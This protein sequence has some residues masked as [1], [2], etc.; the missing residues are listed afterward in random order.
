MKLSNELV[1]IFILVVIL[2]GLSILFD[3]FYFHRKRGLPLWERIGHPL[4][5]LSVIIC[6]SIIFILIPNQVNQYLYAAACLISCV[7]ITKDEFIHQKYCTGGELWI[8]SI[9][10]ILHPLV[11]IMAYLIWVDHYSASQASSIL[12][13]I[14]SLQLGLQMALFIYQII[15]WGYLWKPKLK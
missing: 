3:E 8:H 4:D 15:F 13:S 14:L 2:H 1:F 11:L 7:L 12:W 10:F 5:T 9:L 6:Y